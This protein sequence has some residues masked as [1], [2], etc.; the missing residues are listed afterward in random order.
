MNLE[1][2]GFDELEDRLKEITK[3]AKELDGTHQVPIDELFDNRFMRKY[4]KFSSFSDFLE[5]GGWNVNS[6]EDFDAIP[7]YEFNAYIKKV[8]NF[9]DLNDMQ[10]KAVEAYATKKLGFD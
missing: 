6:Q 4:T 5:A 7:D 9:D 1:V 10:A 2:S 3:A 8:T